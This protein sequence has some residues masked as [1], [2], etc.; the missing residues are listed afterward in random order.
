MFKILKYLLDPIIELSL[1]MPDSVK[2]VWWILCKTA[3]ILLPTV[4]V[5]YSIVHLVDNDSKTAIKSVEESRALAI[6]EDSKK[7]SDAIL[8]YIQASKESTKIVEQAQVAHREIVV[9]TD[10]IKVKRDVKIAAI[11]KKRVSPPTVEH[12]IADDRAESR[13]NIDAMW[14]SF[15]LVN[16]QCG[17]I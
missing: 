8:E 11:R 1:K 12:S 17:S 4:I 9:S 16:K 6:A 10:K 3:V 15:C 5:I 2:L 14:E 13:A 7:S